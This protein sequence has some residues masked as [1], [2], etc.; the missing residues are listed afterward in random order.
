MLSK[1]DCKIFVM[2]VDNKIIA[3]AT[4]LIE[5]KLHHHYMGHIE[6]VAVLSE[7]QKKG[8]GKL[9]VE[10][11]MKYCDERQC[12]KIVL[13]CRNELESFYKKNGFTT[14]GISMTKYNQ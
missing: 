9:I 13:S 12:Y 3:T 10:H 7:F 6:D 14:K 5:H 11:A 4:V 1:Q 8:Y 2:E